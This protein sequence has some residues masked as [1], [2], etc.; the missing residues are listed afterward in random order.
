MTIKS[1]YTFSEFRAANSSKALSALDYVRS[2]YKSHEL[3]PDFIVCYS[4]LYR[5]EIRLE[6]D[7]VFIAD[8]FDQSRYEEILASG[9]DSAAA[10][11]WINLFEITGLFDE[12]NQVQAVT[13][14]KDIAASWNSAID[15][16]H[17]G[18]IGRAT[19]ITDQATG[20]VFISIG[21]AP[22]TRPP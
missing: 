5:P 20:E 2:I 9:A 14:A 13:V 15:T 12:L 11:Y 7:R 8:L 1:A 3:P 17:P 16:T 21:S 18:A 4:R 19:V 10:Q 22:L 6:G